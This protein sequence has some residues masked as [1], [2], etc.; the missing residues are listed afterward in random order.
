VVASAGFGNGVAI[1]GPRSSGVL[2]QSGFDAHHSAPELQKVS[3]VSGPPTVPLE[4]L[5]KPKPDYTDEGRKLKIDGEVR[6][7]V[8]FTSNGQ[9][10]VIKVLQGL[11]YGLDEQAVKA[12]EQIKFKPALHEGR[13]VDSTAVVHIVFQLAS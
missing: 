13:P 5:S 10:H 4:I 6:L 8:L 2:Q 11:G 9:I 12:A 7:E 3:V 1:G